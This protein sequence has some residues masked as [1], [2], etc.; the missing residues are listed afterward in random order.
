MFYVLFF[1]CTLI[2]IS[3]C[4]NICQGSSL[5]DDKPPSDN[6]DLSHYNLI[7]PNASSINIKELNDGYE[8][9]YFYTD[10]Q[11]G[12]MTFYVTGNGTATPGAHCDRSEL[13]HFCNPQSNDA[14]NYKFVIKK[15]VDGLYEMR[16]TVR[17][18]ESTQNEFTYG[19]IHGN[20]THFI[21]TY[22]QT[23]GYIYTSYY[24]DNNSQKSKIVQLAHVGHNKFDSYIKI[25]SYN[26]I[27]QIYINNEEKLNIDVSYWTQYN[28]FKA[29]AYLNF[30][31]IN[32]TRTCG[33]P[34]QAIVHEY[35]LNITLSG[36]YSCV[37]EP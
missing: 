15:G 23:D 31:T 9:Q 16:Q 1:T 37:K 8:S 4:Q 36:K 18:D 13:R 34:D 10:E 7:I 26:G 33:Y 25:N 5:N 30:E 32:G 20:T 14:D 19:Q 35:C 3:N 21:G 6:F 17:I 28:Y 12:S 2:I 29:G 24:L 27:L 11:D 22:W